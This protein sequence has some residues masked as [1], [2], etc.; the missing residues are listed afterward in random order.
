MWSCS[1]TAGGLRL[2]SLGLKSDALGSPSALARDRD[3]QLFRGLGQRRSTL[4]T[5]ATQR[6]TALARDSGS[7]DKLT[8]CRGPCWC[9]FVR[10]RTRLMSV[11]PRGDR[12]RG[13]YFV[14]EEVLNFKID[15]EAVGLTVLSSYR[16]SLLDG[17]LV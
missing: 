8:D 16:L 1:A 4:G 14:D 5:A 2:G 6:S 12:S 10:M 11:Y 13:Q 9:V 17:L 3:N 7:W 15:S